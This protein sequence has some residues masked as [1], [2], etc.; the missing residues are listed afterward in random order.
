MTRREAKSKRNPASRPAPPSPVFRLQCDPHDSIRPA[1]VP[2]TEG[3]VTARRVRNEGR[4]IPTLLIALGRGLDL[5]G[6][7]DTVPVGAQID[8][9]IHRDAAV[10]RVGELVVRG[11]SAVGTDFVAKSPPDGYTVLLGFTSIV[12]VPI[13]QPKVPYD[14]ERDLLPVTMVAYVPLAIAVRADSPAKTVGDLLAMA[15]TTQVSY[16]TFG[17]GSTPHIYSESLAQGA[18]VQLTHIPYKGEALALTDVLGGQIQASWASLGLLSAHHRGG[19]VRILAIASLKRL[20][21]LPEVPTFIEQGYTQFGTVSWSGIL[22]P[23]GTPRPVIDR[24]NAEFNKALAIPEVGKSL[25][26]SGIDPVGTTPEAFGETLKADAVRWR[27]MIQQTGIT[28][29]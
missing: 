16:G 2:R 27:N 7:H 11:A 3:Q 21:T 15:K 19:K 13:L 12:Q 22:V 14:I 10:Q 23:A 4:D 9:A 28:A 24:L 6:N 5:L 26:D 18:G 20:H 17:N 8:G 25:A 1:L 29:N